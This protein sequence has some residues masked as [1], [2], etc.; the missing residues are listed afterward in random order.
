MI[1]RF[2]SDCVNLYL[3]GTEWR[4]L[5]IDLFRKSDPRPVF[6]ETA[7]RYLGVSHA[8]AL[9]SARLGLYLILSYIRQSRAL[10]AKPEILLSAYNFFA[11]PHIIRAA[12]FEPRCVDADPAT[13]NID[14]ALIE[15]C[16]T[17]NTVALIATHSHGW[18][19]PM[20]ELQ[21]ICRSHRLELIEDCAHA[22]G[23]DYAGKKCGSWGLASFFSL[24]LT[25][26]I[27]TYSGG[28]LATNNPDLHR[29]ATEAVR[30]Y[31]RPPAV[32]LIKKICLGTVA[33]LLTTPL[34]FDLFTYYPWLLLDR[35]CPEVKEGIMTEPSSPVQIGSL[36]R[37]FTPFQSL[38][39]IR[40][41]PKVDDLVARRRENSLFLLRTLQP[42]SFIRPLKTD[43]AVTHSPVYLNLAVR[44]AK[45]TV[46][47]KH[48]LR[49]GI[50]TRR[51]YFVHCASATGENPSLFPATQGL[52][53]EVFFL[54]NHNKYSTDQIRRLG[55]RLSACLLKPF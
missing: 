51:G 36:H 31:P 9:A 45:R 38:M 6:E 12:G 35:Y 50:D 10:P 53:D 52:C 27:S 8:T 5:L 46:L 34:L 44:S 30:D 28:L 23:G 55:E 2:V 19:C 18:P 54:P 39:G 13:G 47:Q 17:P 11:I 3:T 22:L 20:D 24:S 37:S 7:A 43:Y 26:T 40:Q 49:N 48:L 29:F 25:K 4:G 33:D 16:I 15:K 1:D 21:A 42:F 41:V 14:P 32:P